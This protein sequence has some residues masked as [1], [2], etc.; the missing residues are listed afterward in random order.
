MSLTSSISFVSNTFY[1]Y[2]V[3]F[4]LINWNFYNYSYNI[5][6]MMSLKIMGL[7]PGPMVRALFL[8]A[9]MSLLVVLENLLVVFVAWGME[10]FS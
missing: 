3:Y 10:F 8:F 4:Y 9:L 7:D 1:L 2:R 5:F 6:S